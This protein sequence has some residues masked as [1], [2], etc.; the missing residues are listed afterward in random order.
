MSLG[1]Q[2]PPIKLP[3]L[4]E[5]IRPAGTGRVIFQF[6]GYR[7]ADFFSSL[8]ANPGSWQAPNLFCRW[9]WNSKSDL[10]AVGDADSTAMRG[11]KDANYHRVIL[12]GIQRLEGTLLKKLSRQGNGLRIHHEIS[13]TFDSQGAVTEYC[14]V[15]RAV[16]NKA[17]ARTAGIN[18][19][20]LQSFTAWHGTDVFVAVSPQ[21]GESLLQRF[22]RAARVRKVFDLDW[23]YVHGN[24][25]DIAV[26][27]PSAKNE[28]YPG[29]RRAMLLAKVAVFA[30]L[31]VRS[32]A[33]A[34]PVGFEPCCS[35]KGFLALYRFAHNFARQFAPSDAER[36]RLQRQLLVEGYVDNLPGLPGVVV[37]PVYWP[38]PPPGFSAT[39]AGDITSGIVAALAP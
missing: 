38:E 24:E 15:L 16:F 23:L 13:A 1:P 20:E 22:L 11:V 2:S 10:E 25:L 19:E 5:P 7:S 28:T 30:A 27:K 9:K 39:G 29:L 36:R 26:V 8:T 18:A 14:G 4:A 6:A 12:G 34:V 37:V 21:G 17:K 35:P 33:S 32:R 3:D 31:N